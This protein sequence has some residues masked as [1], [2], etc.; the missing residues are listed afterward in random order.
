MKV[1]EVLALPV[2]SPLRPLVRLVLL[3]A[4]KLGGTDAEPL[5]AAPNAGQAGGAAGVRAPAQ[6]EGRLQRVARSL[7]GIAQQMLA[8]SD[9]PASTPTPRSGAAAATEEEG[10]TAVDRMHAKPANLPPLLEQASLPALD[11][12]ARERGGTWQRCENCVWKLG[13]EL[14]EA[15]IPDAVLAQLAQPGAG[16]AYGA[17]YAL[18]RL[19]L[20]LLA[21]QS[22]IN[23]IVTSEAAKRVINL[24]DRP[25]ELSSLCRSHLPRLV[26]ILDA[27][28]AAR[29]QRSGEGAAG[30]PGRGGVVSPLLAELAYR[31]AQARLLVDQALALGLAGPPIDPTPLRH[32]YL[33]TATGSLS[34]LPSGSDASSRAQYV[35]LA[36]DTGQ[37]EELETVPD[38][39][40]ALL[41]QRG[42]RA[43]AR[44]HLEEDKGKDRDGAGEGP[45]EHADRGRGAFRTGDATTSGIITFMCGHAH[46][47]GG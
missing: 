47:L 2:S 13:E 14:R 40:Y 41:V 37:R 32:S 44:K 20:E 27:R 3:A 1:A 31:V 42:Q 10:C 22:S 35:R 38:Q 15:V 34:H 5:R 29:Q 45:C 17:A 18:V 36:P 43:L 12:E 30:A 24:R 8:A 16:G 28:G 26:I 11:A 6:D 33:P 7:A 4:A 9:D 39:L 25:R 46:V 23:C 21:E 19:I